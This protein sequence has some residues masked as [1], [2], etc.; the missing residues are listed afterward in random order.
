[1][2]MKKKYSGKRNV[3]AWMLFTFNYIGTMLSFIFVGIGFLSIGSIYYLEGDTEVYGFMAGIGTFL[4]I[5]GF[6]VFL[7]L[8]YVFKKGGAHHML[9]YQKL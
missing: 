3:W 6:L 5:V 1:M 9:H 8:L 7:L 2:R 4:V